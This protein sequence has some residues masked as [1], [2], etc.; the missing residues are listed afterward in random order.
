MYEFEMIVAVPSPE[1]NKVIL[2]KVDCDDDLTTESLEQEDFYSL[3][4]E[5]GI[6]VTDPGVYKVHG[7]VVYCDN[8]GSTTITNLNSLQLLHY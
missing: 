1:D 2:L 3:A 5:A 8:S 6:D 4:D 7:D